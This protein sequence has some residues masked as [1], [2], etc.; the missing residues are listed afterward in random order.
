MVE[1]AP[2]IEVNPKRLNGKPCIKGT[3]IPVSII[4][5]N[6]EYMTIDEIV[7]EFDGISKD[8]VRAVIR[9]ARRVISEELPV[10]SI[11]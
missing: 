7:E 11:A 5:A 4:L 8:D 6:L 2:G 1:V 3:R 9:Y 10:G